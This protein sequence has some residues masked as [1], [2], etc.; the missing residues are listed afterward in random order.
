MDSIRFSL[1]SLKS[2]DVVAALDVKVD[3]QKQVSRQSSGKRLKGVLGCLLCKLI[4]LSQR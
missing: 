4:S 1:L 3:K 2:E